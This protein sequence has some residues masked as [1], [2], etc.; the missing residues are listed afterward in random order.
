MTTDP[1][2]TPEF[3]TLAAFVDGERVDTAALKHAL[4]TEHGRDY[5]VDL[6]ATREV[7]AGPPPQLSVTP[8]AHDRRPTRGWWL[9]SAAAVALAVAG[10]FALGSQ[11][12]T[13]STMAAVQ[14]APA[15][16]KVLTLETGVNWNENR[17]PK[18]GE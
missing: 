15:P 2:F 5:L 3:E 14:Q 17:S 13:S 6:L 1:T 18:G 7:I 10:G 9:V 16:T 11:Q 12:S 8:A 4:S